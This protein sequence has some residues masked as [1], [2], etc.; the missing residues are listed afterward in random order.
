MTPHAGDNRMNALL[1][2][3]RT[4]RRIAKQHG[5]PLTVRAG[6]T[7]DHPQAAAY[8]DAL[9]AAGVRSV[10]ALRAGWLALDAERRANAPA[11]RDS[12]QLP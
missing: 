5:V 4:E 2:E 6:E 8:H 1:A 9:Q 12:Q 10:Q 11:A 3:R 7:I